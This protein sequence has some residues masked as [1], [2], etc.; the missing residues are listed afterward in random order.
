MSYNKVQ[1]ECVSDK[2]YTTGEAAKICNVTVRTIQYYDQENI[3]NP[4]ELS[5]GGRRMYS[6]ED[7]QQLQKICMVKSFGVSLASIKEVMR[8]KNGDKVLSLLIEEQEKEVDDQL[9]ELQEKKK[10]LQMVRESIA[11]NGFLLANTT[12]DIENMMSEKRKLTKLR[13]IMLAVGVVCDILELIG[14][15]N[16]IQKGDPTLFLSVLPIIFLVCGVIVYIY[17]Q[18]T[19]FIC[20]ECQSVFRPK[21][22]GWLWAYHTPKMR[23]VRCT[24]CGHKGLCVEKYRKEEM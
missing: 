17:Y 6:E 3:L 18:K 9:L 16:W 19:E 20:P 24:A 4:S 14:I 15:W 10:R 2:F 5:E 12:N 21:F 13:G 8:D 7:I 1:E 23:K 11:D 22:W